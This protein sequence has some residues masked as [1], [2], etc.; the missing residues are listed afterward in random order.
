MSQVAGK[1][2]VKKANFYLKNFNTILGRIQG[3]VSELVE[4]L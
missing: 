4:E 1:L 3:I 2:K